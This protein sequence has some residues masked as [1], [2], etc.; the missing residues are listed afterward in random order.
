[1]RKLGNMKITTEKVTAEGNGRGRW[2]G[3]ITT[4]HQYPWWRRLLLKTHVG[5][6]TNFDIW[7]FT[8]QVKIMLLEDS[9]GFCGLVYTQAVSPRV[10]IV[11]FVK[12]MLI[13]LFWKSIHFPCFSPANLFPDAPATSVLGPSE[14]W[15]WNRKIKLLLAN[16]Y[17]L[18]LPAP[19]PRMQLHEISVPFREHLRGSLWSISITEENKENQR[20]LLLFPFFL[21]R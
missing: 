13:T 16:I 8:L 20:M 9:S 1:M 11:Q 17:S 2:A 18:L 15:Y 21:P 19:V 14:Q 6:K 4:A 7:C 10:Y 12:F 3:T 5:R